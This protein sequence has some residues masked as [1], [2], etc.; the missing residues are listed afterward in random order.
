MRRGEALEVRGRKIPGKGF[1]AG[2]PDYSPMFRGRAGEERSQEVREEVMTEDI[3]AEDFPERWVRRGCLR[4]IGYWIDDGVIIIGVSLRGCREA[5]ATDFEGW[6]CH[7]QHGTCKYTPYRD[8][9]IDACEAANS[10][11]E[12][13]RVEFWHIVRR[14]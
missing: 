1:Q 3:G 7:S 4:V 8:R 6:V 9:P 13:N 2:D 12:D 11:I 5:N 10:G 14:E